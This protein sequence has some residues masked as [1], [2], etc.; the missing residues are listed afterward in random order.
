M[1]LSPAGD[2]SAVLVMSPCWHPEGLVDPLQPTTA[3][4]G[5]LILSPEIAFYI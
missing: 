3:S 1:L 4:G 5:G 2:S